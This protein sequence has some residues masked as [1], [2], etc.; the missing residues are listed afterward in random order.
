MPLIMNR[1]N[2]EDNFL[3]DGDILVHNT[4]FYC[5]YRTFKIKC[6][7]RNPP[8]SFFFLHNNNIIVRFIRKVEA[9]PNLVSIHF[10]LTC[11]SFFRKGKNLQYHLPFGG[12][13]HYYFI[14]VFINPKK[15]SNSFKNFQK[16]SFLM[17]LQTNWE[18]LLS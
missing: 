9:H 16:I 5:R 2:F 4:Y 3:N 15:K 7:R 1:L 13:D 12:C 11:S 17:K 8:H 6:S 14:Q 18:V 10:L